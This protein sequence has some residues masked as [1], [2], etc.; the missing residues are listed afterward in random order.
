MFK[1]SSPTTHISDNSAH[2]F[3]K[4]QYHHL[5]SLFQ[6]VHLSFGIGF[7]NFPAD[8]YEFTHFVGSFTAYDVD[9]ITSHVCAS[10]Q[11]GIN[12]WILDSGATNHMTPHNIYFTNLYP[13]LSLFLSLYLMDIK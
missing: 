2:G 3:T 9:S 5:M 11:L 1:P 7:E 4:E 6:Q 12:P 10:S 8:N 13:Y